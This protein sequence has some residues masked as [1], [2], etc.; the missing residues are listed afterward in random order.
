MGCALRNVWNA[1]HFA[2]LIY[3]RTGSTSA[4][5]VPDATIKNYKQE[6]CTVIRMYME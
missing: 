6:R 5:M 1:S 3:P 4:G 2:L